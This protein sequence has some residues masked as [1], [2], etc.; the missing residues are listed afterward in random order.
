MRQQAQLASGISVMEPSRLKPVWAQRIRPKKLRLAYQWHLRQAQSAF[1]LLELIVVLAA[2]GVLAGL[3]LPN[4][5]KMLQVSGN[6]EAS[7]FMSSL[8]AECLQSYRSSTIEPNPAFDTVP[9]LLQ[10]SGPPEDYKLEEGFDK[11][12]DIL[13]TPKN[14]NDTL[15]ASYGI[16]LKKNANGSPYI[17][18]YAAYNHPDAEDVCKSWASYVMDDDDAPPEKDCAEGGNVEEIRLRLEAEAAERERV[19]QIQARY[20][21][22]LNGPPP[23]SGNY[24]SDGKDVWAFRGLVVKDRDAYEEALERACGREL[25]EALKKA[26]T[27]GFD[28]RYVYTSKNG[29][30]DIDTYLCSGTEVG[31]KDS[32][33]ACKERER[34]ERC[35]AA[36]GRWKDAGVNGKFS[37][38]GCEVKWQCSRKIFT[39]ETDYNS[40]ECATPICT[41]PPIPPWYC[42]YLPNEPVC[43]C[44]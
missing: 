26:K 23:G 35:T 40:S 19:R 22:W 44:S 3:A 37:E 17:Y 33:D 9:T 4:L 6:N 24:T 36:E 20:E 31:S 30:C 13:I 10:R 5:L 43:R 39:S 1:S 8:A 2:L 27:E 28:G 29:G 34:E 14:E 15:L 38:P 18:K 21:A 25:V 42:T 16:K 11:C 7:S 41:P 32:Y 12:I